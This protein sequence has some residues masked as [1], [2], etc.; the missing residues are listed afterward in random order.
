MTAK[1]ETPKKRLRVLGWEVKP[2]VMVD[3]GDELQGLNVQAAT[4]SV[5]EWQA[6]KDGKDDDALEEIRKQIEEA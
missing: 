3:D 1:K 6:F 4:I 5:K 2:L